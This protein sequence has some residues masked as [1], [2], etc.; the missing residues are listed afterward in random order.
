MS[1]RPQTG[2]ESPNLRELARRRLL[3]LNELSPE[4][5]AKEVEEVRKQGYKLMALPDGLRI[6]LRDYS[7]KSPDDA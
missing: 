1:G 6:W 4:E 2:H 5:W 3:R 7:L